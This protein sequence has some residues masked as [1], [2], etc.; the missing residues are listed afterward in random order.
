VIGSQ[1]Q[2]LYPQQCVGVDSLGTSWHV[3]ARSRWLTTSLTK[4][5]V[6]PSDGSDTATDC[7]APGSGAC[8]TVQHAID[9]VSSDIDIE[10]GCIERTEGYNVYCESA[11]ITIKVAPGSYHIAQSAPITV[12][13]AA[14]YPIT[15]QGDPSNPTV[16]QFYSDYFGFV[17]TD[18]AYLTV[19]GVYLYGGMSAQP[20][21]A[22]VNGRIDVKNDHFGP[23]PV[24]GAIGAADNGSVYI[25]GDIWLDGTEGNGFAAIGMG[26]IDFFATTVHID[27]PIQMT[28]FWFNAS[29]QSNIT[30]EGGHPSVTGAG[31]AGSSGPLYD[32]AF[33]SFISDLITAFPGTIAGSTTYGGCSVNSQVFN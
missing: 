6:D 7:L 9:L 12:G 14:R 18:G 5:Y 29:Q 13:A 31:V 19:D 4:F 17:A 25:I 16:Y 15:I 26:R 11:G 1:S 24:G 23:I 2:T 30:Y 28:Q 3:D 32:C 8:A 22:L 33:D 21:Q 20:I 27:S 10:G